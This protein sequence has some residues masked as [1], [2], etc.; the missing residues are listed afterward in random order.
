MQKQTGIFH[1]P[2][3]FHASG[4][5][6]GLKKSKVDL[7]Y[8]YSEVPAQAAGVYTT[9]QI[10]AAPLTL[11]KTTLTDNSLQAI[12]VNSANANAC[13]GEQGFKNA[14]QMQALTAAALNL[15]QD[16]VAVAS[17]GVI[18]K[19][20]AMDKIQNGIQQL[21]SQKEQ[22]ELFP[23]TIL[24][25]DTSEKKVTIT[26]KIAGKI[27]TLSACAKGSGMI[28][29]NMATM[30]GFL[31]CDV[32]IKGQLLEE[33]LQELTE[34]T[35]NQIT[36]D[37]DTSTN[38]MVLVLANGTAHNKMIT[39]KNKDYYL[40]KEILTSAMTTLAKM[41]A[42]DGE[43]AS[44]LI[45][46]IVKNAPDPLNARM[47]A[48]AI[49]GSSLVKTAIF[50]QDP[51]WGRILC[52]MGY[53]SCPFDPKKVTIRLV[54]TVVFKD[55]EPQFFDSKKLSQKLTQDSVQISVELANGTATATAWGCDLT[56]DYVKI[57]ALYQT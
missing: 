3:G 21:F 20:L 57:N 35:F 34:Q 2:K 54:D 37:G 52:S 4:V 1:L 27:V 13:T 25:T 17:T 26:E 53:S 16:Q 10:K 8:L 46:V 51:N 22:P 29:P 47:M 15:N 6:C 42:K 12:I 14:V 50:G 5:H 45:E 39:E 38:D 9:N 23:K 7:A 24:T 49:V 41:I 18:G 32:A 36:I 43:G 28:H 19:Q 56:Y 55:G 48:K 31:A 30:L 44:K 40:F 11:S 33:L